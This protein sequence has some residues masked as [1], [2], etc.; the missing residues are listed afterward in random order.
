M[1]F[2]GTAAP[3]GTLYN[4][5]LAEEPLSKGMMYTSTFVRHWDTCKSSHSF[6]FR[7]KADG[8]QTSLLRETAFGTQP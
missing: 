4:S 3:N 6:S 8:F 5:A 1:A 7:R 2:Y